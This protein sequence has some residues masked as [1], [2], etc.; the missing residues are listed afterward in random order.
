[1]KTENWNEHPKKLPQSSVE[2]LKIPYHGQTA[3]TKSI[4][5]KQVYNPAIDGKPQFTKQVLGVGTFSNKE[6]FKTI[7]SGGDDVE[8]ERLALI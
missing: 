4:T 2:I 1:M 3:L 8:K 7:F 5:Q 6:Y